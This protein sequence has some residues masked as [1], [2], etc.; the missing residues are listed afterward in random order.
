ME[1]SLICSLD[2]LLESWH[3]LRAFKKTSDNQSN[4]LCYGIRRTNS[5]DVFVDDNDDGVVDYDVDVQ[6]DGV[7]IVVDDE[8]GGD[9]ASCVDFA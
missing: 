8:A 5:D 9:D 7:E 4:W 3:L 2:L 1:E 6:D